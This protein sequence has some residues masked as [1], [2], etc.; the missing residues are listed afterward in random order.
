MTARAK[1]L[2]SYDKIKLI[3]KK[4]WYVAIPVHAGTSA[5]WFGAFF[6]ATKL[7]LDFVPYLEKTSI[8]EKYVQPL[9]GN[10]GNFAQ[11]LVLYKVIAPIR[12][13]TTLALTRSAIIQLRKR[14]F[15]K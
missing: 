2:A 3:V 13:A 10:V 12:Y 15:I 11:A 14:N 6:G 4:Y 8:P 9:K 5:I 7:G 1:A